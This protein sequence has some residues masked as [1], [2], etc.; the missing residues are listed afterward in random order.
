M[1]NASLS[2]EVE[3]SVSRTGRQAG[4]QAGYTVELRFCSFTVCVCI[5]DLVVLF[6]FLYLF[7]RLWLFVKTQKQRR[8]FPLLLGSEVL[9]GFFE[10]KRKGTK[11]RS[12]LTTIMTKTK[13]K[14]ANLTFNKKVSSIL[15]SRS[16]ASSH[17]NNNSI[18]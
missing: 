15:S 3:Q 14:N 4:R 9:S 11:L 2:F 7:I 17:N 6:F 8:R 12:L 16:R 1:K 5:C 13:K 10:Q 18:V